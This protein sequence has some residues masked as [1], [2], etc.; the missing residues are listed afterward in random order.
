MK[1]NLS[2]ALNYFIYFGIALLLQSSPRFCNR[3]TDLCANTTT[4]E[5]RLVAEK[6]IEVLHSELLFKY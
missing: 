3:F 4:K 2:T 1:Q 6:K 5:T